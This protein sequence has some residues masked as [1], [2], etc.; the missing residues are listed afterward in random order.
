MNCVINNLSTY[1]WHILSF[2]ISDQSIWLKCVMSGHCGRKREFKCLAFFFSSISPAFFLSYNILLSLSHPS[3][4]PSSFLTI[5]R[6]LFLIHLLPSSLLTISCFLFLI[7]L[8]CLLPFVRA[9][10]KSICVGNQY[11]GNTPPGFTGL[12]YPY[13]L[14]LCYVAQKIINVKNHVL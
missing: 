8:S 6:F 1:V 12:K 14:F 4:L 9:G 11:R 2:R 7:H 10:D 3:L 5:S 13:F